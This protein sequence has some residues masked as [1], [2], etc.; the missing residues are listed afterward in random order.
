M[1]A[2]MTPLSDPPISPKLKPTAGVGD[3]HQPAPAAAKP[4]ARR[5]ATRARTSSGAN[6]AARAAWFVARRSSSVHPNRSTT[7]AYSS[8]SVTSVTARVSVLSPSATPAR[9]RRSTGGASG[10]ATTL[11][12]EVLAG[13]T[14][15]GVA[16]SPRPAPG[17]GGSP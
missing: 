12:W 3:G 9:Y 8:V 6:A 5:V 4:S 14:P 1:V 10:E 7:P 15:R 11:V 13:D 17:G 2:A 16:P